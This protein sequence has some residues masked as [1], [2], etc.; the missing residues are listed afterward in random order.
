MSILEII[1]ALT[2][3]ACICVPNER[4]KSRGIATVI[5]NFHIN[6]AF[7]TPSVVKLIKPEDV[8]NLRTLILG[9]EALS[10]HD[11]ETWAEHLQLVNGYGP[12]EC[13]IAAAGNPH[14][15]RT[16]DPANIGR[17][18]GGVC[19]ITEAQDHNRLAPIGTVGELLIE[20]PIVARGYL[21]N[22]EKTAEVFIENPAWVE[23]VEGQPPRRLYKTGDLVH[24]NPD[25]TINFIGRKDNQV[26]V[27]GQ[28]LELGKLHFFIRHLV[29]LI[30]TIVTR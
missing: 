28:R 11:V 4:A 7:L 29:W 21:N 2:V 10:T 3:G 15:T 1:T 6:W 19:W 30:L 14:L 20:G 9:G 17:A 27:R 16:T 23:K 8:P 13:S 12:S 22:P 5:N 26:K 25:G 24:Y 18:I